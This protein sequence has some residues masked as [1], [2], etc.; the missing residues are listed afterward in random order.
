M[1]QHRMYKVIDAALVQDLHAR[2]RTALQSTLNDINHYTSNHVFPTDRN[3]DYISF[4]LLEL[5]RRFSTQA[6][7]TSAVFAAPSNFYIRPPVGLQTDMPSVIDVLRSFSR[8][9]G[10]P[11]LHNADIKCSCKAMDFN[12]DCDGP[13][14]SCYLSR[15][16]ALSSHK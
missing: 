11:Y 6:S 5:C 16:P 14:S 15:C 3:K 1:P 8:T 9:F 12:A 2:G 10:Y 4:F 13:F 7:P